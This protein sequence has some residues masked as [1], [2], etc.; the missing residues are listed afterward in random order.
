MAFN[1][2]RN[3]D[4]RERKKRKDTLVGT[5]REEYGE[6]FAAGHRADMTLG[7]LAKKLGLPDT[8][9]EDEVKRKLKK[10]KS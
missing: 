9:S 8:A 4:G 3:E 6:N 7:G 5:L 10:K 1:R 2:S